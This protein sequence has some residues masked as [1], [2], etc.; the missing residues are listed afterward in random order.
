MEVARK[1][2]TGNFDDVEFNWGREYY[3]D[4][5]KELYDNAH[6]VHNITLVKDDTKTSNQFPLKLKMPLKP[7]APPVPE[8]EGNNEKN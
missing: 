5:S 8:K 2:S 6:I 1:L 4:I 7:L 3:F